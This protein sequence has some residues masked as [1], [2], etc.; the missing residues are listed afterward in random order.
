[1]NS[2]RNRELI[3]ELLESRQMFAASSYYSEIESVIQKKFPDSKLLFLIDYFPEQDSQIFCLLIDGEKIVWVETGLQ[4][5][6]AKSA[7]IKYSSLD[8]YREE[9]GKLKKR[10]LSVA[11]SLA[12]KEGGSPTS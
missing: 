2:C 6:Q 12:A 5:Y 1:M 9:S 8:G 11:L 10:K 4:P 3:R 7:I